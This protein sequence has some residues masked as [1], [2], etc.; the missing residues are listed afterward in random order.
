ML[1]LPITVGA[2]FFLGVVAIIDKKLLSRRIPEPISYAFY[3]GMLNIAALLL[4]PFGF[5]FLS[6]DITLFALSAGI[7]FVIGIYFLYSALRHAEA[8]RAV[9]IIGAITTIFI[10]FFS[11]FLARTY[12]TNTELGAIALFIGGGL[13]LALKPEDD[14][15]KQKSAIYSYVNTRVILMG[16]AAAF[17]FAVHLFLTKEVFKET[18]FL[19]GFV[20]LRMGNVLAAI[21]ILLL[22]SARRIILYTTEQLTPS[23]SGIFMANQL[24]GATGNILLSFAI[25]L[26]PV[27][28]INAVQGVQYFFIFLV[29]LFLTA[30]YPRILKEIFSPQAILNKLVGILIIA[31]GFILLFL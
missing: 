12:L 2:Y 20:W 25:F 1:W 8:S 14:G 7:S 27:T 21:G 28:I 4:V 16:L 18:T 3:V 24:M 23:S 31:G 11:T 9:P 13:L 15:E 26:G 30:F 17:F 19:S 29:A 6:Y 5:Q 22:P 10:L